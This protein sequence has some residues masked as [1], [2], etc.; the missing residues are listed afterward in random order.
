M[1]RRDVF[2]DQGPRQLKIGYWNISGTKNKIESDFVLKWFLQHASCLS[3]TW[4]DKPFHVPGVHVRHSKNENKNR[5]GV[6]LYTDTEL[7]N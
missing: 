3:E 7:L 6:A 4:A 2:P 1:T 5:G